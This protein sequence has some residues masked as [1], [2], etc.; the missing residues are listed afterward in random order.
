[1]ER[2]VLTKHIDTGNEIMDKGAKKGS[3]YSKDNKEQEM[4]L[5]WSHPAQN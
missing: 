4:D 5:S 2:K 3:K 1:M